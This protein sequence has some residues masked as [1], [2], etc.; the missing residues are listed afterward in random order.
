MSA[1][2]QKIDRAADFDIDDEES[3][4]S[5]KNSF[6]GNLL[7]GA[8][9]FHSITNRSGQGRPSSGFL[10]REHAK[11]VD[12]TGVDRYRRKDGL[13]EAVSECPVCR[14]GEREFVLTRFALDIYRCQNCTHRY[15]DP[16]VKFE[17]AMAIYGDDKTASDIYTQPLQIEIDEIK[18]Q[19][20]LDLIEKLS[21]PAR[22][23]IMDLGCGAG[24]Y[25]KMADRNGWRQCIGIDANNRYSDIYSTTP[26]VQ[27]INSTFERLDPERLGKDYDVI[28]MWSVLEHLYDVHAILAQ[29][30]TMLKPR[31]LLFILVPNVESL[32]TR[33]MRERSPTFN[34]KHV[35]HFS[36]ESLRHIMNMH[37]LECIFQE[38]VITEIDNIKSYMSGAYPYHGH[39]DP[40]RLFD[41]ITPEYLHRNMLGSRQI[42]IFRKP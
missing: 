30:R 9:D 16:R 39:G 28:S 40:E 4:L 18:Y 13:W 23:K 7:Y 15:L 26:G 11:V 21:P 24:V 36:P 10:I 2:K 37:D 5:I 42:A 33:L 32:A 25:L 31:G 19:Y 6:D 35:S 22:D 14:S 17:E 20:G 29:L 12:D 38:T 34:W 27:F 3:R 1:T 41:F 8:R